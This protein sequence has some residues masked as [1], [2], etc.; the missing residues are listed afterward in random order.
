MN[1]L[2]YQKATPCHDAYFRPN[3]QSFFTLTYSP[4]TK[5]IKSLFRLTHYNDSVFFYLIGAPSMLYVSLY[6]FWTKWLCVL[7]CL[8]SMH[9]PSLYTLIVFDMDSLFIIVSGLRVSYML[10]K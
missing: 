6:S 5:V 10:I 7:F 1:H 9:V 8:L 2:P 4:D 3:I